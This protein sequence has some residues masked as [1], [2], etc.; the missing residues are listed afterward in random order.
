MMIGS[1]SK[2]TLHLSISNNHQ[3]IN[4]NEKTPQHKKESITE[5]NTS[6]N[7]NV[8]NTLKKN[9]PLKNLMEQ[10]QK[11]TDSRQKYLDN[12]LNKNDSSESI[13]GKL[14]EYDKQLSEVDKQISEL[15]LEEQNKQLGTDDKDK[16]KKNYTVKDN[17]N[18]TEAHSDT[19][20]DNNNKMMNN[21]VS[22]STNMSAAKVLH[23]EKTSESGE[24]RVLECEIKIDEVRGLNPIAKKKRVAKLEYNI[25]NLNEKI[26]D[27]LKTSVSADNSNNV[28]NK[29]EQSEKSKKDKFEEPINGSTNDSKSL[30]II[31]IYKENVDDNTQINGKKINSI[32]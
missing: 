21:L 24:K 10:K 32:T 1:S 25:E 26:G 17:S 15:K 18:S 31:K 9:D 7:N 8:N 2:Q 3:A 22:L 23:S 16:N 5:K 4:Y 30:Q 13:K 29:N 14:A 11:I 27:K 12:A 20:L 6:N 28:V 19:E